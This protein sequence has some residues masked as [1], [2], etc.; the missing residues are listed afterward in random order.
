MG[1]SSNGITLLDSI[2]VS[3]TTKGY[4][5]STGYAGEL[6]EPVEAFLHLYAVK[7]N[8]IIKKI[9]K[10][11]DLTDLGI[12]I[13]TK[14]EALDFVNLSRSE[15][16]HYLF[17]KGPE[18]CIKLIRISD[19]E[20]QKIGTITDS[21]FKELNLKDT[22]VIKRDDKFIIEMNLA[23]SKPVSDKIEIIR[24]VESVS[25]SG[26]YKLLEKKVIAIVEPSVIIMPSYE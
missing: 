17:N 21:E 16:T 5:L 20:K 23:K 6:G 18:S 1:F 8:K 12:E 9:N 11:Q 7:E 4:D 26:E 14:K 3:F 2:K 19:K 15:E 25:V 13:K 22:A 24:V 10:L